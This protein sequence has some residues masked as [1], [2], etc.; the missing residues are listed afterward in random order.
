MEQTV[1]LQTHNPPVLPRRRARQAIILSAAIFAALS[2]LAA[3][4]SRGFLE[5]DGCTHFIMARFALSEPTYLVSVWGRPLVTAI[6]ALPASAA[7]QQ[8]ALFLTR[9]VSLAM[10]LAMAGV[11]YAIAKKQGYRHPELAFLF[12]LAE[13]LL[14][15][16]SFA[17][18]T[19]VPFALL[20]AIAF[21]AYQGRRFGFMALMVSLLP[22]ARPEGF[23]FLLL[24]AIAL[25]LH[26]RWGW[27]ILLPIP[28]LLWNH[29]G[30]VL[31][32]R[33]GPWWR[34]LIDQWPY[35]AQ[36]LYASGPLWH[37]LV[38][39]PE[40]ISPLI[41]PAMWIGIALILSRSKKEGTSTASAFL[42]SRRR[43]FF[44]SG[45]HPRRCELL[46]AILP[47]GILAAHSLLYWLGK[48]A[49]NGEVRYLLIVAPFWAL[50]AAQ[51]WDRTFH[52]LGWRRPVLWGGLAAL[53]PLLAQA[54][55]PVVP[56]KQAAD[57]RMAR[58]IAEESTALSRRYPNLMASH[59]GIWWALDRS[60]NGPHTFEWSVDRAEHPPTGTILIWDSIYSHFN[61]DRKRSITVKDLKSAGWREDDALATRCQ[62]LCAEHLPPDQIPY[63]GH[64][65]IFLSPTKEVQIPVNQVK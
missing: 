64:W 18:L 40:I 14:F 2:A 15:L 30:W 4:A 35:A 12:L 41:F 27:L 13:P 51:G 39:L 8:T 49:S 60:P 17:V 55:Y 37:F 56:L 21:W 24:A 52:R 43:A 54:A 44:L 42:P 3:I 7:S 28:L 10:V 58:C 57:W 9:L 63:L 5:A 50:L 36:S 31:Y 20:L 23:G 47:L 48:M 11:T 1:D 33:A 26:R 19:E 62:T 61:S 32:G 29:A 53:A 38:R 16:H 65:R 45:S 22:L 46:I 34:W 6:Y 25:V 59:P